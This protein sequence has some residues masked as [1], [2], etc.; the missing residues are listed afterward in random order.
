[1]ARLV[2]TE[3][4]ADEAAARMG[5][6]EEEGQADPGP[7]A[8][9][10]QKIAELAQEILNNN[11]PGLVTTL[12]S[13]EDPGGRRPEGNISEEETLTIPLLSQCLVRST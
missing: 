5:E 8:R 1:M 2:A 6:V 12:I 4:S 7:A 13:E 11:N 10:N 3:D 9:D